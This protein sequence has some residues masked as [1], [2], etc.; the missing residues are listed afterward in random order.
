MEVI[1]KRKKETTENQRLNDGSKIRVVAYARVST[2]LERQ[3][4]SFESQKNII[5]K[6]LHLIQIG[7]LVVF[8]LMKVLRE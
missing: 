2:E 3:Q 7:F 4:S 5:L 8:I 6:K 1:V